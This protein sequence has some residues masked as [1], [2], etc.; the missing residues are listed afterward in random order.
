MFVLLT[1][2]SYI[3]WYWSESILCHLEPFCAIWG[4]PVWLV[5]NLGNLGTIRLKT[6]EKQGIRFGTFNT[7][8]QSQCHGHEPVSRFSQLIPNG[9]V[10]FRHLDLYI[11]NKMI[12]GYLFSVVGTHYTLIYM[13]NG[14]HSE[15]RLLT[16]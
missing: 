1:D 16:C 9:K 8:L 11:F 12:T 7:L 3:S 6:I 14:N 13:E 4:S 10:L 5:N 2:F 15:L